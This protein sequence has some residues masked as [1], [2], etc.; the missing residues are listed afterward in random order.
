[1]TTSKNNL[2]KRLFAEWFGTL[3]LAATVNATSVHPGQ[4]YLTA[5]PW[6]AQVVLQAAML[7]NVEVPLVMHVRGERLPLH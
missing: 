7:R 3:A 2:Q 1:M 6:A 4:V 5:R